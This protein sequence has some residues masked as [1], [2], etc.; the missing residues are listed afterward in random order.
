VL[1]TITSLSV[2]KNGIGE[3]G[4]KKER[5]DSNGGAGEGDLSA[6]IGGIKE[7]FGVWPIK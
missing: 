5:K 7:N 1:E 4:I 2:L 6:V 3:D